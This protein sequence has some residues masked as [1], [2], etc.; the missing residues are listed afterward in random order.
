MSHGIGPENDET[1]GANAESCLVSFFEPHCGQ[2]AAPSHWL[3]GT[4]NSKS[5]SHLLQ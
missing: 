3:V 1:V 5:V 4:S 2:A